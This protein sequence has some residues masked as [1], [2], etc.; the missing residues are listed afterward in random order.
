MKAM[1]K[2]DFPVSETFRKYY[3]EI[4]LLPKTDDIDIQ[5]GIITEHYVAQQYGIKQPNMYFDNYEQMV[6]YNEMLEFYNDELRRLYR[7]EKLH[8]EYLR[9]LNGQP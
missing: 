6:K 1:N 4:G 7:I 3:E 9:S 5:I 2:I 8:N